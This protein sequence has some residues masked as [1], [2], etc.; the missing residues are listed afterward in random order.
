MSDDLLDISS[1]LGRFLARIEPGSELIDCAQITAGASQQTF[2]LTVKTPNNEQIQYALRRE[3]PNQVNRNSG[4]LT[5]ALEARL[6]KLASSS[7]VLVP[8]IRAELEDPDGLG[9]GY[10][11]AWLEGETLGQ[12][13]VKRPEFEAVRQNL[14]FD[15]GREL[16]KIHAIPVDEDLAATLSQASPEALVRET[17]SAYQTLGSPQPMIDFTARWLLQ[18][19]PKS[20]PPTLVHGDFRN[21]NLMIDESGLVAVL[22]W[23]LAHIGDPMRDLGWLCVNSWRFGYSSN[24]VG[25][26]GAVDELI[27]GYQSVSA[28]RVDRSAIEFWQVFGSFWWSVTTL[29]M[30]ATW[31]SG[32]TPSLERPVIGRRSSE[33]QLDC[34]NLLLPGP[35]SLPDD[36]VSSSSGDLPEAAELISSVSRYLS[37]SVAPGSSGAA[38]FIARVAANSLAIAERETTIG[39]VLKQAEHARLHDIFGDGDLPT[40]RQQ[41]CDELR[42]GNL[43]EDKW[44]AD[45]LRQTAVDRCWVDQPNYSALRAYTG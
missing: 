27:T 45:H 12:R 14:A 39:R 22:D 28:S 20:V 25:G 1:R 40:L 21:G 30:A 18:N 34:V 32:E 2:K 24:P 5:A 8:D 3:Q 31:R 7:G 33:A 29:G 37:E 6:L 11:M 15:C 26:F 41:L 4:Q 23:E 42:A 16:A 43:G 35:A 36:G 9:Q 19:L 13:I 10:L 44:V 38:Q 17:W